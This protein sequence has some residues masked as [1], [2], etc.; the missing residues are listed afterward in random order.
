MSG[1]DHYCRD[2]GAFLY[3]CDAG[4]RV[5]DG[6]ASCANDP[7]LAGELCHDCK[8]RAAEIVLAHGEDRDAGEDADDPN[9]YVGMG[10]I[11]KDGRP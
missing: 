3:P 8:V 4:A 11:G 7:T 2:C 1:H 6:G 9:D 5:D 10:W